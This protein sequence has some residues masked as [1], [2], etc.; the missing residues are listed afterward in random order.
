[1]QVVFNSTKF[2]VTPDPKHEWLMDN[3]EVARGFG[4]SETTIRSHKMRNASDFKIDNHWI[5]VALN[6]LFPDFGY[7]TLWT[8]RG[9]VRLGML[10]KSKQAKAFRDW[11]EELILEN[12][13]NM[14]NPLQ[15]MQATIDQ[16]KASDASIQ[17]LTKRVETIENRVITDVGYFTIAGFAAKHGI[18]T[19]TQLKYLMKYSWKRGTWRM[20]R[21]MDFYQSWRHSPMVFGL[22]NVS[23][24]IY[25]ITV[26]TE[27]HTS[28]IGWG[29]A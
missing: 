17:A 3:W 21:K 9:I 10:I 25:P 26:P 12:T 28:T 24:L 19:H 16:L 14:S 23:I 2:N 7:K 8:K 22:K 20:K 29:L 4:V 27:K 5:T 15:F 11:C 6:P 13:I 1:M 18:S